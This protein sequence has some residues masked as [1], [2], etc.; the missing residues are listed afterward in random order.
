MGSAN[1]QRIG[2]TSSMTDTVGVRNN[3]V[4]LESIMPRRL[5]SCSCRYSGEAQ[6]FRKAKPVLKYA[7]ESFAHFKARRP[8]SSGFYITNFWVMVCATASGE[9]KLP[10][11]MGA[12]I[13]AFIIG[14][15]I[16]FFSQLRQE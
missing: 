12:G 11:I 4:C 13:Y 5:K 2:L 1:L 8:A 10:F 3:M 14:T 7:I 9:A 16:S 6:K 15:L